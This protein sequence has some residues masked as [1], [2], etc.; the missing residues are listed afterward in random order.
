MSPS[1]TRA[2]TLLDAW[3][4]QQADRLDPLRFQFMVALERRAASHDGEV[5]RL[6]D[7]RLSKLLDGYAADLVEVTTSKATSC[8]EPAVGALG[9]L[10]DHLASRP[11]TPGEDLPV[12]YPELAALDA[13]RKLWSRLRTDSH[14]R[15]SLTPVPV[16]AGPLNSG[17]LAHR[18]I[19][20]MRELSPVYLQHFLAYVDDLSWI[21][22]LHD[23]RAQSAKDAPRAAST[24]KRAK[25]KPR[26]P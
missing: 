18:A 1:G 16:N 17:A 23:A 9:A 5:R 15:Q 10:V 14:L 3:R 13:F 7:E 11:T 21:E 12:S 20:L 6:L 2:G 22:R 24:R 8:G 4:E 19:A 25:A 26:T